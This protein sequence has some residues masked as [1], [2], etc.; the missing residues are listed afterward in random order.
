MGPRD[1]MT[2]SVSNFSLG[3]MKGTAISPTSHSSNPQRLPSKWIWLN[4][5]KGF[6]CFLLLA[7]WFR[8]IQQNEPGCV[9]HSFPPLFLLI[10]QIH[11]LRNSVPFYVTR[12][13]NATIIWYSSGQI[14]F[15]CLLFAHFKA[16]FFNL[17]WL[18]NRDMQ[19]WVIGLLTR[20]MGEL[21]LL[22]M[23]WSLDLYC[24]HD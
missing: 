19:R 4:K 21:A 14:C 10:R 24:E 12:S 20:F 22:F 13:K 15:L 16:V 7:L 11:W 3:S 18:Q 8:R 9:T 6:S 5:Y 17:F 1:L 2:S 23:V